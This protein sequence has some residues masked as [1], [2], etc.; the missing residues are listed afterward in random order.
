[1]SLGQRPTN[2]QE[3]RNANIEAL[4]KGVL[5]QNK[6]KKDED[7]ETFTKRVRK[8][9]ANALGAMMHREKK[10]FSSNPK[11]HQGGQEC[12]RRVKQMERG[13]IW[14]F[15]RDTHYEPKGF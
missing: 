4:K 2:K 13:A 8:S 10:M 12:A 14:N 6:R 3:R 1:M 7:E 5:R 9:F 15:D 11:P